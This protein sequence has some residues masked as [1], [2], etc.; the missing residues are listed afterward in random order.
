MSHWK[1]K[2]KASNTSEWR[3]IETYGFSDKADISRSITSVFRRYCTSCL[4][5]TVVISIEMKNM[6]SLNMGLPSIF[7]YSMASL[8]TV[9]HIPSRIMNSSSSWTLLSVP[10]IAAMLPKHHSAYFTRFV[11]VS[12]SICSY[13]VTVEDGRN[14]LVSSAITMF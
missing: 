3:L 2:W 7:F 9:S 8:I 5:L 4:T 1:I 11:F 13:L 12:S 6:H 14:G 10:Y